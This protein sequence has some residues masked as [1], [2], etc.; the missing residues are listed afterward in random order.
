M[1]VRAMPKFSFNLHLHSCLSPCGSDDMT[2]A[3]V[4]GF[5]AAAG[6]Q[7]AALTDHNTSLN[8]PAFLKAC[9]F[10]GI[11]GI[12]GM[13]LTTSEEVHV[14]CLF[15][16]LENA[17]SFSSFVKEKL[18]DI[19]NKPNL[20][21]NQI[22]MNE[23]D[24][25]IGHEDILLAQAS[26]IGI[27]DIVKIIKEYDGFAYPA[28]I[29]KSSFSLLSNLGLWDSSMG[30]NMFEKSNSKDSNIIIEKAGLNT[31]FNITSSDAHYLHQIMD[32][33]QYIEL[34]NPTVI[35]IIN[36]FSNQ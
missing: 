21:G 6:I 35:N 22:I 32:E 31:I 18:P 28:H 36:W 2:P 3:Q 9:D 17:L 23:E 8:C 29:D 12:A 5:C 7:I 30:F 11:T 24:E 34:K 4:A 14:I 19:K 16:E 27:Y 1:N 26:S 15:S 33:K 25:I 20:F 13:E 10:Y